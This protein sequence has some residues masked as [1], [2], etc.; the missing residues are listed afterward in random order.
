MQM[1]PTNIQIS[2][3]N[4]SGCNSGVKHTCGRL[5]NVMHV[6]IN[7]SRVSPANEEI[8]LGQLDYIPSNICISIQKVN[9]LPPTSVTIQ[10]GVAKLTMAKISAAIKNDALIVVNR[11]ITIED[12]MTSKGPQFQFNSQIW[13]FSMLNVFQTRNIQ[14]HKIYCFSNCVLLLYFF[15]SSVNVNKS[16]YNVTPNASVCSECRCR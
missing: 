12:Q 9:S 10:S 11:S 13:K 15:D 4:H 16:Q 1:Q 7:P 14:K 3:N 8:R 6:H 5:Y 2:A